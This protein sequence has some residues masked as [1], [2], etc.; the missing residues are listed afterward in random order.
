MG[1]RHRL[2]GLDLESPVKLIAHSPTERRE[3]TL[4]I[5]LDEERPVP[6]AEPAGTLLARDVRRRSGSILTER[7]D[8]YVQRVFGACEF[9]IDKKLT[10]GR[11]RMS[12][13]VGNELASTLLA[14]SIAATV[15]YLSAGAVM[16]AGAVCWQ[17]LTIAVAGSSGRGKSTTLAMLCSHG[18][19]LLA[20]DTLRLEIRDDDVWGFSGSHLL[21]LRPRAHSVAARIPGPLVTTADSRYGVLA[22]CVEA[23]SLPLDVVVIPAPSRAC[24]QPRLDVLAPRDALLRLMSFPRILG[25]RG[26]AG[27]RALFAS[28]ARLAARVPTVV[29]HMPW[30]PPFRAESASELLESVREIVSG[31]RRP[32]LAQA[33]SPR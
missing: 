19:R 4:R 28:A 16:H 1:F 27:E 22:P 26:G 24:S 12:P 14:G 10:R 25:C 31:P 20:E 23:D 33:A 3:P 17:G 15:A 11:L 29:A 5:T 32:G 7:D 18:A 9:E 8:A 21:R 2:C 6:F 13:A 30:G